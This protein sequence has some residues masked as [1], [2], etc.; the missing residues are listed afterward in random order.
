[1]TV[2]FDRVAHLVRV[3][4]RVGDDAYRFLVDT[5]IGLTVVSPAIAA[6]ADVRS[7]GETMS[8]RRMSGQQIE[9]PL[10]NLPTVTLGEYTL[11]DHVAGVAD[12]GDEFDG[13]LGP[14]SFAGHTV[15]TDP[16][17]RTLTMGDPAQP[18]GYEIPLEMRREGVAVSGFAAL[19][20]PSGRQV[21]VEVDTGSD[22]LILDTRF[23]ADCG[24]DLD[25][26]GPGVETKTAW[27]RPATTGRAT[28]P[29]PAGRF[30]LQP[31]R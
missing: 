24:V 27:M 6:R 5:G 18:R 4:V 16:A 11:T 13:I 21:S 25:G 17:A 31:R 12:L 20:L 26:P 30:I 28:G 29:L 10:V 15:V 7:T 8:G 14:D 2:D 1:M 22:C 19:V 9:A 23:A 3:P